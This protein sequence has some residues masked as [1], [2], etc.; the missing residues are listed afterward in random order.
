VAREV[1]CESYVC[2]CTCEVRVIKLVHFKGAVFPITL[3]LITVMFCVGSLG[4]AQEAKPPVKS[5]VPAAR[6][7]I[8]RKAST[9]S[10][11]G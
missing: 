3:S 1:A 6:N 2:R 4:F 9:Q 10:W 5:R 7:R 11:S 8:P